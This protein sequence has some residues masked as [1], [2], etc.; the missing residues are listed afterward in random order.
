LDVIL[1]GPTD[2]HRKP[3][4]HERT[5]NNDFSPHFIKSHKGRKDSKGGPRRPSDGRENSG[6]KIISL[7]QKNVS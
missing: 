1:D 5:K 2:G 6:K 7:P 4:V 3:P